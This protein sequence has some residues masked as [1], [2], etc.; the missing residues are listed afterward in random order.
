V[1]A[2]TPTR[3]DASAHIVVVESLK[4]RRQGVFRAIPLPEELFEELDRVHHLTEHL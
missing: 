2:L 4:K 1:L 3:I